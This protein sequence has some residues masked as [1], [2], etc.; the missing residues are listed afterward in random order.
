M[1]EKAGGLR[2]L[3]LFI[4]SVESHSVTPWRLRL[5]DAN[6]AALVAWAC[7]ANGTRGPETGPPAHEVEKD[8]LLNKHGWAPWPP[9]WEKP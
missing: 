2:V 5:S 4:R 9:I 7:G 6:N 8:G 1:K 3:F